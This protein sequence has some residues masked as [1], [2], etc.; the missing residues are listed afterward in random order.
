MTDTKEFEIVLLKRGKTK[1]DI[2]NL[3][4]VTLQTIYNKINNNVDFKAREII[5]ISNYLKL[6]NRE[7]DNI[8]FA[9]WVDY[10]ST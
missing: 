8:F 2:A 6:T 9:L 10:K 3:L 5:A 7:R 1:M 4:G